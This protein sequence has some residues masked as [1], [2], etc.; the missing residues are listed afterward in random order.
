LDR[1]QLGPL[2]ENGVVGFAEPQCGFA[3]SGIGR[4]LVE[5][6]GGG[7]VSH[8]EKPI[9]SLQQR[10]GFQRRR[11]RRRRWRLDRR[12]RGRRGGR[13][14]NR[15]RLFRSCRNLWWFDTHNGRLWIRLRGGGRGGSSLR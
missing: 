10:G 15:S 12:H 8:R 13:G 9:A 4:P 7:D 11:A 3:V 5:K 6:S 2:Q 14:R 1:T